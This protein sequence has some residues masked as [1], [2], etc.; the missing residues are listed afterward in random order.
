VTE[1]AWLYN[2]PGAYGILGYGPSSSFW[3]QFIDP[4]TA[5]ATFQIALSDPDLPIKSNI[6]LGTADITDYVNSTSLELDSVP[7]TSLYSY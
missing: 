4:D 6:T 5:T 1:D 2:Q 7:F 3:N